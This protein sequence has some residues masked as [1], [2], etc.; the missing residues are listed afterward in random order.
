MKAL[1]INV[2]RDSPCCPTEDII[3]PGGSI[4]FPPTAQLTPAG[5]EVFF[6]SA[7][8]PSCVM[9]HGRRAASCPSA[10]RSSW[11]WL[12]QLNNA[13]NGAWSLCLFGVVGTSMSWSK[14]AAHTSATVALGLPALAPPLPS[15]T[16]SEGGLKE[17]N[18]LHAFLHLHHRHMSAL[19]IGMVAALILTVSTAGETVAMQMTSSSVHVRPTNQTS[20]PC[21]QMHPSQSVSRTGGPHHACDVRPFGA[22]L[23]KLR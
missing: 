16:I 18:H 19:K 8:L 6:P 13:A 22:K 12:A 10:S 14:F 7:H 20:S 2:A 23:R 11:L 4:T 1:R 3:C 9:P 5:P 17:G 15:L 21:S